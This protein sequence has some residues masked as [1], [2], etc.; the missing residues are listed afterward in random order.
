[1]AAGT[2]PGGH[3][4][5]VRVGKGAAGQRLLAKV[6]LLF[7]SRLTAAWLLHAR[8]LASREEKRESEH[9]GNK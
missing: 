6:L 2:Q 1:M 7:G 4:G 9:A 5:S 3:L 8:I